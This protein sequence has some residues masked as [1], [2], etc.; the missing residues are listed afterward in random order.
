[1]Q[2]IIGNWAFSDE[3]MQKGITIKI[4]HMFLSSLLKHTV[5]FGFSIIGLH[6]IVF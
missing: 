3:M 2:T 6:G 4:A 5:F 1:M